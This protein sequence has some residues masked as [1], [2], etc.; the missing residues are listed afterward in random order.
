MATLTEGRHTGEFI[1]STLGNISYSKATI[2]SGAGKVLAGTVIGKITASGKYVP[3]PA[4][5]ADGSQ[6]AVAVTLSEVDATSADAEVAIV[7]FGAEVKSA[8]LVYEATVDDDTKKAAKVAQL[9]AVSIK[10]R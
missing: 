2:A 1:L 3:S 7:D 10:A 6:T 5:G 9:R 8:A 4:T